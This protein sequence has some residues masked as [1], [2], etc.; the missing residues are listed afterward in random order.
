MADH[1]VIVPAGFEATYERFQFAPA[2]RKGNT[3]FVSG[4]IGSDDKGQ[5]LDT[6]DAE[7]AAAFEQLKFTLEQAGATLAD[8]VELTSFH[9]NI[10]EELGAFMKA[11]AAVMSEP[12]P[13]WTA[14]GCT[15]LAIPGTRAEVK[16]TAI[17][18]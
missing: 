7:F 1:D 3:I 13:A 18:D 9:V 6:P 14:I 12:H 8:V 5:A 11:K 4:V 2:V 17:I 10:G 16:A 15:A